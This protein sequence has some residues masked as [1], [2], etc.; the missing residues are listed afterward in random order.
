[1][2]TFE[3]TGP[4]GGK[5]QV[6][7]PD[8]ATNDQIMSYVQSQAK[9]PA[10]PKTDDNSPMQAGLIGAGRMMTQLGRGVQQGYYGL[11]SNQ[12]A[13]DALKAKSDEEAALY[14]PLQEAHP[15]A[16]AL[17]E[18]A[19]MLAGGPLTMAAA[20]AL[21]YG[22]PQEKALR[23]AGGFVGGK[24]GQAV[25]NVAGRVLQ[26]VR[27]LASD[28]TQAVFDKF[29]LQG[30]PGQITGSKPV[31]WIEQTLASLPGGGRIRDMMAAQ[32]EGLNKGAMK[33][34]G[35]D[36][37]AVTPETVQAGKAALGDVFQNVPKNEVVNIDQG[38]AMKLLQVERDH[39]KNLS[40]DQRAVVSQYVDD[41]LA[42]GQ[43]GMPGDVYQKARSRIAARANSTQDS[44]LKTA[45]TGIYKTLDEA[46]MQSAAPE[47]G[48][49]M[50]AAR[51]Q[52]RVAKT[53][54]KMA[55]ESGDISA[56]RVANGM[57]GMPGDAGDLAKLG[58]KM[59]SL[60]NSGTAQRLFYQSLLSGGVG[61][62]TQLATGDPEQAAKYAAGALAGPWLAS[63][64]LTRAP[65]RNYLTK[66][67]LN[68]SPEMER[69]LERLGGG[70]GGA[71]G[72][73]SAK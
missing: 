37:A 13:Q 65:V 50:Q 57:K 49:A 26:P 4:D 22:T 67:L 59:R 41:I 16:T 10:A 38:V 53:V 51:S 62:G 5:Y 56:A 60:P 73:L 19:P 66:G 27:G 28:A 69:L 34:M 11:T 2:A 9:A 32:Q 17:G 61:A 29:G 21:E 54:E 43:N 42:H 55:N 20:G 15:L 70:A 46:F 45:L 35:S 71:I 48:A 12:S 64:M 24:V 31:Q 63:Q 1:M 72:L 8:D 39:L 33:A 58:E 47:A 3:V 18:G 25:G 52:Y 14:K 40:P 23:A 68:V 44:E 30:L 7:A 6:T 36:A